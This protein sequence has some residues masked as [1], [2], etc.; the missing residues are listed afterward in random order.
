MIP[1]ST[2]ESEFCKIA[3]LPMKISNH[4][5]KVL[6]NL[7]ADYN[8]TGDLSN[9]LA[10]RKQLVPSVQEKN[11]LQEE[12]SDPLGANKYQVT[13]RLIHQYKNRVLLLTT[14]K[15]FSYCRYCF[16]R[17]YTAH[18]DGWITDSEIEDVCLYLRNHTEV[19]E[20]LFS[21]GDPLTV[22]NEKLLNL[23]NKI[24]EANPNILIRICTRAPIFA[25]ERITNDLIQ[26]LKQ[27]RPLWII[28]HVNHPVEISEEFSAESF[29]VLKSLIDAGISI[30]SQTVL[31]KD[32]NDSVEILAK[33]FH[34]LTC[35]G[36]KPGYLFQGD[37]A[38]GTSHF[39]VQIE[40]GV[41]LYE[42][43]RKELSGLSTP[44]YA[45]DLPGGGGKINL[46]QLNP[47]LLETE[48]LRN[49]KNYSFKKKDGSTWFYPV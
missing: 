21:G 32:I 36:I 47:S 42:S 29:N 27:C 17:S 11:I 22:S 2:E 41:N 35:L 25:P 24:R 13:G 31:L 33:L 40:E 43:L 5:E 34:K 38:A 37:L 19:Q 10:L 48:V 9:F 15:C 45:V 20:I 16:R 7:F 30:Q 8:K 6:S 28:L 14:A 1:L 4:M 23:I 39:R 46:L 3:D 44:V 49:S 12:L 26:L 18:E